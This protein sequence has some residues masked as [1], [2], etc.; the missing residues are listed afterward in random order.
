MVTPI[1]KDE[2]RKRREVEFHDERELDRQRLSEEEWL[3]KYSNKKWY[4]VVGEH[5][6][7]VHGFLQSVAPGARALDYCCGLGVLTERLAN[8]G[9]RVT[10]IDISPNSV[11]AATSRLAE[12][13]L[14]EHA[15]ARVMD[16]EK[17]T[18]PDDEFDLIVC[19]GVLHHLDL[20]AAYKELAR[21]LK[22]TGV[23]VCMEALDHNPIIRAYRAKTPHLRTAWEA[24]HIL[25][26][27]QI[28]A[29]ARHFQDHKIRF[30][31]LFAILGVPFRHSRAF[32]AVMRILNA[33]DRQ[34][35]RI[36]FI[37]RMAWQTVF[38]LSNPRRP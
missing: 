34:V 30:Y 29:S 27:S 6:D 8:Y 38:V 31:Y 21:V 18:F 1:N 13:G 32:P 20:D 22:P 7:Y 2:E 14:A 26:V 25:T 17:L 33:I 3:R 4:S 12:A 5:E 35:L 37:N 11:E 9:A 19:W 16:A 15:D 36:P 24:K 10:G 23:V 28:Q